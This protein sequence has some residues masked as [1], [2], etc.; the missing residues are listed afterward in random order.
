M[1]LC[2]AGEE[3]AACCRWRRKVLGPQVVRRAVGVR[4]MGEGGVVS[5]RWRGR[6]WPFWLADGAPAPL[7]TEAEAAS[8]S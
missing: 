3:S 5:S 7:S 8:T 2:R 6:C 4:H 1:A